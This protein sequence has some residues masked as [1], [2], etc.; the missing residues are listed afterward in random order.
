MPNLKTRFQSNLLSID[1]FFHSLLRWCTFI[2][3]ITGNWWKLNS[4]FSQA[5][6]LQPK[7]E[8]YILLFE[9]LG[10]NFTPNWADSIFQ[11][12]FHH[13]NPILERAYGESVLSKTRAIAH[14]LNISHESVFSILVDILYMRRVAVRLTPKEL[15][16]LQK[17][18][19]ELIS[20]NM[21]GCANSDPTLI[22]PYWSV[23]VR[24]SVR[25]G[26]ICRRTIR[27]FYTTIMRHRKERQFWSNLRPK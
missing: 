7:T 12:F 20:L 23:C 5:F 6:E 15:N 17:Q 25:N 19:C 2:F 13:F 24:K 4:W 14:D 11:N 10:R 8:Q 26:Q 18:Y 21:V 27:G 1:S 9:G 22:W 3:P 16:F